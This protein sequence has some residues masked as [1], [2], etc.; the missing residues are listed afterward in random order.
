MRFG[1]DLPIQGIGGDVRRLAEFAV[2]AE[3][4]GWEFVS[5]E[6]Y[7][8]YYRDGPLYDP[9]LALAAMAQDTETIRL[10]I[11]VSPLARRRPWVVARQSATLDHLS[12][13][14]LTLGVGLG[15]STDASFTHFAGEP[16]E[17][18]Q[19]ARKF[20]EALDVLLG[21]W[22]GR[23][24]RYDGD[25]FQVEEVT[26]LPKPVQTPRIPIW[27]GGGWPRPGAIRRA[28]RGD[29]AV[30]YKVTEDY[31]FSE[32]TPDNIRALRA[33][34][35]P[36]RNADS[37]YGIATGGWTAG[38]GD[39]ERR[40]KLEP[41]EEAGVTWWMEFPPTDPDKMRARILEGPPRW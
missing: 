6:D 15:D 14:R 11:L 16:V 31:T 21:L 7:T 17:A 23:P 35:E 13:G 30:M 3:G 36:L 12:H 8:S 25:H 19:R 5:L 24:F 29:A 34:I 2:L 37:P 4:A 18:T 1:I 40:A 28:A 20:D 39:E 38:F 9:W 41:L 32:M 22:S 10:G 26:F 33:A 27:V